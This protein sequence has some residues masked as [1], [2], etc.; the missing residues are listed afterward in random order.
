MTL[1]DFYNR[2]V[3]TYYSTMHQDS[4]SAAQI[5][6]ANRRRM[7]DQIEERQSVGEIKIIS[8]VRIK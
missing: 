1:S 3:P 4:Y 6:M 2:T 8:E 7:L 5:L